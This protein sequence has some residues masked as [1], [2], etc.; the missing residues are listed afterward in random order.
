MSSSWS[1]LFFKKEGWFK[2]YAKGLVSYGEYLTVENY[3]GYLRSWCEKLYE[4]TETVSEEEVEEI[5][6]VNRRSLIK[7]VVDKIEKRRQKELVV[8]AGGIFLVGVL[9]G[10]YF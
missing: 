9:L 3:L 2:P 10:L 7:W 6:P 1:I 5:L 8:I 4:E